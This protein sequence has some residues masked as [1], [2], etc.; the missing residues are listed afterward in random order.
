MN[1][2]KSPFSPCL[3]SIW[4]MILISD[5]GICSLNIT[6]LIIDPILKLKKQMHEKGFPIIYI[7]DHYDLWQANFD[8]I[9]DTC[10]NERK[11]IN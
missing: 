11:P 8:K 4:S 5:T 9:I 7:N 6:K 3:S 10:K 1:R 2:P